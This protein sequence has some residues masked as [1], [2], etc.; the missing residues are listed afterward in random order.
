[1]IS[2][3]FSPQR[4]SSAEEGK[5]AVAQATIA[6]TCAR[7]WTRKR[8]KKI[9]AQAEIN[10]SPVFSQ[11]EKYDFVIAPGGHVEFVFL[12]STRMQQGYLV[13]GFQP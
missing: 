10:L 5:W 4:G 7:P 12:Q 8:K 6:S 9:N 13:A 11:G 1:M 2:I 3:F